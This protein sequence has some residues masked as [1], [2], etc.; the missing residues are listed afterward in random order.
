MNKESLE[1]DVSKLRPHEKNERIY[2]ADEDVA[3][4]KDQIQAFGK[5][6]DALKITE[7]HV[8]ISGHRRWKAAKELGL[9]TVPC[10]YV[11]FG[12]DEEELAALVLYNYHRV[13]TNEQKAREGMAL[14]ET[15]SEE[16]VKRR[17][18]AIN[19]GNPPDMDESSTTEDGK[20]Q[21]IQIYPADLLPGLPATKWPRPSASILA[22]HLTA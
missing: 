2:G 8:I 10:Q 5:I 19:Q 18:S 1:I 20:I 21:T 13:K 4:L 3:D 16:A 17:L 11:S 15:L 6:F 7:E 22:R 9:E 12:S 14:F